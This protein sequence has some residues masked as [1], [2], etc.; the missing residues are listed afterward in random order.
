M[1]DLVRLPVDGLDG[2]EVCLRHAGL[3]VGSIGEGLL[4]QEKWTPKA[5]Q[6]WTGAVMILTVGEVGKEG[7]T[8][9]QQ[10]RRERGACAP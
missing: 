4:H 8:A 9:H 10:C 6:Q 3:L 2:D 5:R 7:E 1:A